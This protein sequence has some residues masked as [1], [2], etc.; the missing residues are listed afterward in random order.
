MRWL[1]TYLAITIGTGLVLLEATHLSSARA[2]GEVIGQL[3]VEC[4]VRDAT[5]THS[6]TESRYLVNGN[7][8][9]YSGGGLLGAPMNWTANGSHQPNTKATF[10]TLAMTLING[11]SSETGSV[12]STMQCGVDPWRQ[13]SGSPCRFPTRKTSPPSLSGYLSIAYGHLSEHARGLPLSVFLSPEQRAAFNK[14]YQIA[15]AAQQKFDPSQTS[16]LRLRPPTTG[17]VS[18]GVGSSTSDALL[19]RQMPKIVLPSDGEVVVQGELYVQIQQPQ[20]GVTPVAEIEWTW[21]DAPQNQPYV[22]TFFDDTKNLRNRYKVDVGVTRG[23][24][25]R[26]QVRARMSGQA[27][28]GPWSPPTQFRL[29][30]TQP[31]QTQTLLPP[32]SKMLQTPQQGVG[33]GTS[34]IRPQTT[35]SQGI[36]AG[37][38][39]ARPRGVDEKGGEQSNE[40]VDTTPEME[41]KP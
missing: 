27:I 17:P 41:K 21:L 15:M 6:S 23:Q 13:T 36:G 28:P 22:N 29:V 10:E 35:P 11:K 14:Q 25:G 9:F 34:L 16:R 8:T 20:I 30:A 19:I 39:L 40:T 33:A 2:E 31:T 5:G 12:D 37:T 38:G 18:A 1:Q 26:W 24:F 4:T 3:S 32:K 7:C